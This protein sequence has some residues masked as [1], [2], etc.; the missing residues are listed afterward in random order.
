MR[1]ISTTC[2]AFLIA[3][4]FDS[5]TCFSQSSSQFSASQFGYAE[6]T[7]DRQLVT[8]SISK[9]NAVLSGS[10]FQL[11]AS[12]LPHPSDG[13]SVPVYLIRN[14][15]ADMIFVP[16]NC[17]CVVI[18]PQTL[19]GWLATNSADPND[20]AIADNAI[21]AFMLLHEVGHLAHHDKEP[22]VD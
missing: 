21:L 16:R 9:S 18:V 19:S 8:E 6:T 7:E 17:F 3:A 5:T 4:L 12:W 14:D 11:V 13:V 22:K 20:L 10:S 2:V 1:R 15:P